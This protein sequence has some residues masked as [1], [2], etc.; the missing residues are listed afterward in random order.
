LIAVKQSVFQT[1]FKKR[2][3]KLVVSVD[4]IKKAAN[5]YWAMQKACHKHVGPWD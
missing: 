3:L 5:V 1:F 4:D 2:Q